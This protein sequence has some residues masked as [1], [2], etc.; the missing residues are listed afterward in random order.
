MIRRQ[1]GRAALQGFPASGSRYSGFSRARLERVLR[2]GQ[3]ER[4]GRRK[5]RVHRSLSM[6]LAQTAVATI[7]PSRWRPVSKPHCGA[8][9]PESRAGARVPRRRDLAV[10]EGQRLDLLRRVGPIITRRGVSFDSFLLP[11]NDHLTL[12]PVLIYKTWLVLF[13]LDRRWAFALLAVAGNLGCE[14]LLYRLL[15]SR[16]GPWPAVGATLVLVTLG[17]AWED[18]LWP[19]Q[20]SIFVGLAGA[21]ASLIALERDDTRGD[22]AASVL[23]IVSISSASIGL[24][25]ALSPPGP[26]SSPGVATSCCDSHGSGCAGRALRRLVPRLPRPHQP[27]RRGRRPDNSLDDAGGRFI[28]KLLSAAAAAAA[29]LNPGS[30]RPSSSASRSGPLSPT[31]GFRR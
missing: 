26:T 29:G 6:R 8:S 28:A 27:V 7:A 12:L 24:S 20:I 15:V 9:A 3:S 4:A 19:W 21:L 31:S 11:H 5:P 10:Q 23:L 1:G 18:L 13:G 17:P 30:D 14:L 25:S 2:W 22:I 16:T